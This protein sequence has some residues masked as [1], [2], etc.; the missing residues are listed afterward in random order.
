MKDLVRKLTENLTEQDLEEVIMASDMVAAFSVVKAKLSMTQEEFVGYI[1][2]ALSKAIS[3]KPK[4]HDKYDYACPNCHNRIASK[5]DVW[6]Y[7]IV[8]NFCEY[9]GQ[10]LD[11]DEVNG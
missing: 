9:C 5:D 11:W 2:S 6:V 8:P 7:D 4:D 3:E 10:K 1:E